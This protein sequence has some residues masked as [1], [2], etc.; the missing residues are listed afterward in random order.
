MIK[1]TLL[2]SAPNVDGGLFLVSGERSAR[3]SFIPKTG[4]HLDHELGVVIACQDNGGNSCLVVSDAGSKAVR[5]DEGPLDL[6]DVTMINGRVYAAVTEFNSVVSWDS[7]WR[8]TEEWALPG[9][10]D[11]AHLNSI[12]MYQGRLLASIF[13]RF[14]THREYK[15]RTRGAGEVIDVRTGETYITGL[16][17][18]HSLTVDEGLLYLC[19]SEDKQLRVYRGDQMLDCLDLPGYTRGLA[20]GEHALYVG[21]SR[22]RN[23]PV[24]EGEEG[25]AGVC[26]INKKSMKVEGIVRLSCSEVYDIRL[27]GGAAWILPGVIDVEDWTSRKIFELSQ[28]IDLFRDSAESYKKGYLDYKERSDRCEK[29]HAEFQSSYVFRF[30][31]LFEERFRSIFKGRSGGV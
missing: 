18:P 2:L 23:V 3:L 30:F 15:N 4:I 11:A 13:G 8:R 16:S 9:E 6:H 31:R 12:T 29:L 5:I 19:S 14:S 27:L 1:E 25:G 10:R 22:S 7:E 20:V 21:L 26:V 17:Q 24:A 28:Q